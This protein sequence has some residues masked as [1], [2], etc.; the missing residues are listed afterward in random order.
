MHTECCAP[1]TPPQ[2]TFVNLCVTELVLS[3]TRYLT[4]MI[5]GIFSLSPVVKS[6]VWDRITL[7]VPQQAVGTGMYLG[8]ADLCPWPA[9][10][11]VAEESRGRR[12]QSGL[13]P[14]IHTTNSSKVPPGSRLECRPRTC[15]QQAHTR[16]WWCVQSS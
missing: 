10:E 5:L 7:Y 6:M 11:S 12:M 8:V 4:P 9:C 3:D 16:E 13:L 1:P 2:V 15:Q 14:P